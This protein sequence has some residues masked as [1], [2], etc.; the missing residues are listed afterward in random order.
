MTTKPTPLEAAKMMEAKARGELTGRENV[1]LHGAIMGFSRE[2]MEERYQRIVDFS[3]LHD[4]MDT[5]VKNYSSGMYARLGFSIA[6]DVDADILLFDEI[7]SVGD[8]GFQ[9]KCVDRINAHRR[10]GRTVLFVSHDAHAIQWVCQRAI[11]LHEGREVFAGD[12][13]ETLERYR[14]ILSGGT[15]T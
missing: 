13:I 11:L 9:R 4:F 7:L 2:E 6:T 14:D 10:K 8:E 5:A 1:F 3:E 12:V 15:G